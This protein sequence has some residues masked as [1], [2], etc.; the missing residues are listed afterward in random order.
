MV[1]RVCLKLHDS[2][3]D[4][5]VKIIDPKSLTVTCLSYFLYGLQVWIAFTCNGGGVLVVHAAAEGEVKGRGK[6]P[7]LAIVK[8]RKVFH[9][10][11]FVVCQHVEHHEAKCA[12]NILD[13]SGCKVH[14][15]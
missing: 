12:F 4:K 5:A 14:G 15:F 11:I 13:V 8:K 1:S 2:H 10:I 3:A 9:M 6:L 7:T